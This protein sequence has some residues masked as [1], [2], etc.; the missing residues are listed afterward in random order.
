MLPSVLVLCVTR[1]ADLRVFLVTALVHS[2]AHFFTAYD[3]DHMENS[4][5]LDLFIHLFMMHEV[6]RINAPKFTGRRESAVFRNVMALLLALHVLAIG[7]SMTTTY[8]PGL[9]RLFS[10]ISVG[11]TVGS[12]LWSSTVLFY[13]EFDPKVL[14]RALIFQCVPTIIIYV[15]MLFTRNHYD[16]L[17]SHNF[18]E[19]YFQLPCIIAYIANKTQ[20]KRLY[21]PAHVE[22]TKVKRA[23]SAM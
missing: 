13:D 12:A 1:S 7:S 17:Y 6:H 11:P 3:I 4:A 21:A 16:A 22:E 15:A 18:F 23:M 5:T 14:G 19:V 2:A 9:L 8:H 20:S 10:Y